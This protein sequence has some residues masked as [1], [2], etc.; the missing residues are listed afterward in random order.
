MAHL[1]KLAEVPQESPDQNEGLPDWFLGALVSTLQ[2]RRC[3]LVWVMPIQ[4]ESE[5]W[6]NGGQ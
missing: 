4:W 6:T 5:A 1:T 2:E 3:R